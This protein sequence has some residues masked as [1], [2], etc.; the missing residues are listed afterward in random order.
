MKT[1]VILITVL[2]INLNANTTK[3]AYVGLGIGSSKYYDGGYNSDLRDYIAR[4]GSS[5]T[6]S[7][8]YN[9]TAYKLYGGYQF[10]KIVAI[11]A[12][13]T[14]YGKHSLDY[15]TG[16]HLTV[17]PTAL[18]LGVNVGYYFG[19]KNEFRPFAILGLS[20]LTFNE[21]SS[22]TD[23]FNNTTNAIRLGL[24]FE[25]TPDF[26][27]NIGFR[28]AYENDY[29]N[30]DNNFFSAP[31]FKDTYSQYMDSLYFGVQYKF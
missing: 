26:L 5:T 11:E 8:N 7:E 30:S 29:F 19:D 6:T 16:T 18:S 2:F 23:G 15:S 1:I 22:P 28:I 20:S 14:K 25:Y 9:S 13:F 12:S 10:N 21:T 31:E 4:V 24:G 17:N 27:E 3:G